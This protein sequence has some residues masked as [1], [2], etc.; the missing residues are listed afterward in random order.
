MGRC[1]AVRKIT[2]GKERG[3]EVTG[4]F[5]EPCRPGGRPDSDVSAE[6]QAGEWIGEMYVEYVLVLLH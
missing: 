6:P 2:Q 1:S 5:R 4:T 3:M